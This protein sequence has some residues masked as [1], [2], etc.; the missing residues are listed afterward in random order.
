MHEYSQRDL[1]K[2]FHL[3]AT[4]IRSLASAGYI[5]QTADAGKTRYSFQDLLVLR[6]ASALK[7]ARIPSAKITAAM[8]KIRSTLPP[9]SALSTLTLAESGKDLA[10]REGLRI[11]EATSGQY[12]LPLLDDTNPA[13]VTALRPVV[14]PP[15]PPITEAQAHYS[16]GHAL[17]EHD[18]AGAR[19]AY[20]EALRANRDHLEARINLGRL[21]HLGGQL[22]EAERVYR[23]ARLSSAMLSF[24]LAILLEDLNREEEA[25]AAYREALAQDPAMFDAHFNLSRLHEKAQQPREALRHLL[26]YRRHVDG[27]HD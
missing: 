15:A 20:V 21:L 11:W 5:A 26:A 10:M 12:P 22:R 13:P 24:N 8:G 17:E 18:V 14:P 7:S 4:L 27:S 23:Q 9:G 16:R 25:M 19:A 3:P 6:M 1:G 2:L